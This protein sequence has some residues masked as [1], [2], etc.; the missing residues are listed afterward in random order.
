MKEVYKPFFQ[1][2]KDEMEQGDLLPLSI[3]MGYIC[4]GLKGF[5]AYS[6]EN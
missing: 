6:L 4:S 5:S 1:E 3:S 2:K